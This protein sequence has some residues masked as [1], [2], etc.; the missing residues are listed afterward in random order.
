M[1]A[2]RVNYYERHL[3]DYARDT[4]HLSMVEHGAYTLLLDRYYATERGIPADQVHRLARARSEDERAAVDAVLADFFKL[5]DGLWVHG[6]VESEI[7]K[8]N[9]RI[10]AAR[11][12]GKK[13]GNPYKKQAYNEPGFL[14]FA[15]LE[16]GRVKVG[17]TVDPSKRLYGLRRTH[18]RQVEFVTLIAVDDMGVCESR[19]LSEFSRYADG[20]ILVADDATMSDAIAFGESLGV[21]RQPIRQPNGVPNGEANRQT[22]QSPDT[23]LHKSERDTPASAP[24]DGGYLGTA[25]RRAGCASVVMSHPDFIAAVSEGVTADEATDGVEVAKANGVSGAGMWLYAVRT[26]RTNHAKAATVVKLPAARAGP[27]SQAPSRTRQSIQN[28][29]DTADALIQ[30]STAALAHQGVEYRPDEAPDAQLGWASGA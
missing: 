10:N 24:I 4:A 3:G 15:S 20:E 29:Q 9:N 18:G 13:G 8:A 22:Y 16:A 28:L 19:V 26:A 1:V 6:R 7:Q 11:E 23:T 12:N 21:I 5:V 14:Y 17:I 2:C 30:Q 27:S 25:L